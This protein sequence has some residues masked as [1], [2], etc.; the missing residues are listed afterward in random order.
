MSGPVSERRLLPCHN[1]AMATAGK[2]AGR[3]FKVLLEWDADEQVWVSYVPTLG[4]LS[5]HGDTRDEALEQTREAILGYLE[6]AAKEGTPSQ[7]PTPRPKSS[8]SR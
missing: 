2:P 3:R 4:Q 1:E 5:T 7:G 6:A 8:T